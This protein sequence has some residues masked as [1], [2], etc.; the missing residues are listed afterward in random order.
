MDN[1]K[2][3]E[4]KQGILEENGR[5]ADEVRREMKEKNIFFLNLMGS[6]GAGKT[7]TLLKL[8]SDLK[9]EFTI[10]VIEVDNDSAVDAEKMAAAGVRTVQLHT[11]TMCHTDAVMARRGIEELGTDGLDIIVL[12]NIG[13][14]VCPAEFDIGSVKRAVILSAPEGHDKPLKY[15]LMFEVSDAMIVNKTDV[16]EVFDFD[17]AKATENARMRNPEIQVFP[18]SGKA[19]TGF[20]ALEA[21]LK[22]AAAE[23]RGEGK[24]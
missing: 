5:I 11:G 14:L 9:D 16:S 23:W 19:G 15:P 24:A 7:T 10:G 21:W 22:K 13:N 12:E 3:I 20:E 17:L 4:V 18:V 1:V 6:P 2:V 8:I